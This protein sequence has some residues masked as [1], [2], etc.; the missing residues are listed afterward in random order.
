MPVNRLIANAIAY[1]RRF[2]A[3][4]FVSWLSVSARSRAGFKTSLAL[5]RLVGVLTVWLRF[6]V[7]SDHVYYRAE[8]SLLIFGSIYS[9]GILIFSKKF[10]KQFDYPSYHTVLALTDALLIGCYIF[11]TNHTATEIYLFFFLPLI[12]AS[13]F[14]KRKNFLWVGNAVVFFYLFI[15]L[16]MFS[17]ENGYTTDGLF[18]DVVAPWIGKA[19]FLMIGS[20]VLRAQRGL[21]GSN[22]KL[23]V[24]PAK[25]REE[26]E[27]MLD[28]IK[29]V[30]PY[31]TASI[32]MT[33]R[34]R[35]MVVACRG[36]PNHREIYQLEFPINDPRFPNQR[37][38]ES[39]KVQ[40]IP[41]G[42]YPSFADEN[43]N[44]RHV[45]TWMGIP[46]ISPATDECFGMIS[47]DSSIANSYNIQDCHHAKWF[48]HKV[49]NFLTESALAPAALTQATNRE[50]LLG[51]LKSWADVLPD[52]TEKWD[53]D[54]HA[55][56]E[57]VQMGQKI[58]HVEDCSIFFQRRKFYNRSK[59]DRNA[60][61]PVLCLIASTS[62]PQEQYRKHDEKVTGLPGDGLAGF[63]VHRNSIL[64]FGAKKIRRTPYHLKYAGHFKFLFSK[65]S[66]QLMISPLHDSRGKAV[67]AIKIENRMGTSSETEFF[68]VERDLFEVYSNMVSLIL[69][70]IRQRNYIERLDQ[71]IHGMRGVVHHAA[72]APLLKI[73]Q[74]IED[75][76][77]YDDVKNNIS[78]IIEVL[79]YVKMVVHRVL[80]GS[81][82]NLYLEKEGLI[83][84]IYHEQKKLQALPDFT[85]AAAR[86]VINAEDGI[87][88]QIPY[89]IKEVFFN[90]ARESMLNI[91]RHSKIEQKEAGRG[92][93]SLSK[94]DGV[95]VLSIM[96]NGVGFEE[97]TLT[98]NPMRS[99]GIHSLKEQMKYKKFHS[100]VAEV[101]INSQL[102]AGTQVQVKWSPQSMATE[103][104]EQA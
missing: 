54:A 58:F 91:V 35:L 12:T 56:R 87:E 40:V 96:D 98:E 68:P 30:I 36:F 24:S 19:T 102:E 46:L 16:F 37:V 6:F 45:E 14:L 10:I 62:I 78:E 85:T 60:E 64:N 48:A 95:F 13:H 3:G 43:Y 76:S 65:I 32:Q 33:Y 103:K 67:G 69:E 2:N 27:L 51:L 86:I 59:H 83:H 99:F 94:M 7:N 26:L 4:L 73:Q 89:A 29:A 39:K 74:K 41:A 52:K 92:E 88:E 9:L 93:I 100:T 63:G 50:N 57:L 61:E 72:I 101:D 79:E 38:I 80:T 90:V 75:I 84:A 34:D 82:E 81:V 21:P 28:E 53:D 23:V 49:S 71:D 20:L 1:A 18:K 70:T 47:L 8:L 22:A 42:E 97:S 77:A 31:E 5:M 11:V 17:M 15:L 25:A 66:R 44:S 55:A 104:S